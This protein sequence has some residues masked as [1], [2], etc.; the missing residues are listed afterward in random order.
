VATWGG[1]KPEVQ[2]QVGPRHEVL[3]VTVRF[4][5]FDAATDVALYNCVLANIPYTY[6]LPAG[7][8]PSEQTVWLLGYEPDH[9]GNGFWHVSA[10]YG[11][12]ERVSVVDAGGDS[13]GGGGGGDGGGGGGGGGSGGD[14][15]GGTTA[16]SDTGQKVIALSFATT[17]GSEH[18]TYALKEQVYPENIERD[19]HKAIGVN[20]DQIEG[21]NKV[22]PKVAFSITKKFLAHSL[23]SDYLRQ[24]ERET[25]TVNQRAFTVIYKGQVLLL[26]PREVLFMGAQSNDNVPDH[27]W[28]F[29]FSFEVSRNLTEPKTFNNPPRPPASMAAPAPT[30]YRITITTKP[31][32]WYLWLAFV[33]TPSGGDLPVFSK[34]VD[35][36]VLNQI[37]E[38]RDWRNLRL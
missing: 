24:L 10:K 33:D 27:I 37:Y 18:I 30:D 5:V 23:P 8:F 25:G 14:S 28:E 15:G 3:A 7:P 26:N 32:W 2:I 6:T 31:G 34:R 11:P 16:G 36:V 21:V 1:D 35:A 29:T 17:G 9:Q 38:E 13:A 20:N 19:Y 4:Q 12:A 22:V